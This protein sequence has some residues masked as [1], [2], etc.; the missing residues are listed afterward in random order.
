MNQKEKKQ[1]LHDLLK[2]KV[3]ESI[4]SVHISFYENGHISTHIQQ[5][6]QLKQLTLQY[7]Q[8]E[9]LQGLEPLHLEY[10]NVSNNSLTNISMIEHM[11]SLTYLDVQNNQLRKIPKMTELKHLNIS[12]NLLI[13]DKQNFIAL[14]QLTNL[15]SLVINPSIN[16]LML[17]RDEIE[18]MKDQLDDSIQVEKEV[19]KY[20]IKEKG[21]T[22]ELR[23]LQYQRKYFKTICEYSEPE[24]FYCDVYLQF[25]LLFLR[26]LKEFNY[27]PIE[28]QKKT[29]VSETKLSLFDEINSNLK[30]E[31]TFQKETPL[32]NQLHQREIGMYSINGNHSITMNKTSHFSSSHFEQLFSKE[33]RNPRQIDFSRITPG[34]F[35]VSSKHG[36]L[37]VGNIQDNSLKQL[38]SYYDGM[39]CGLQLGNTEKTKSILL[40]GSLSGMLAIYDLEKHDHPLNTFNYLER[41]SSVSLNSIGTKFSV[42]GNNQNVFIYDLEKQ[43]LSRVVGSYHTDT[44]NVVKFSNSNP[45]LYTACCY[46]KEMTL[47][48]IR[49]PC[50]YP[51]SFYVAQTPLTSTMFSYDDQSV[52]IGGEDGYVCNVDI[53]NMKPKLMK[54]ERSWN[55]KNATRA[56]YS[57]KN[58][59]IVSIDN[60]NTIHLN[61]RYDGK[62]II[63]LSYDCPDNS[64]NSGFL[65]VKSNPFDF[66]EFYVIRINRDDKVNPYSLLRTNL[67]Y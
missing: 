13:G 55:T 50:H 45:F 4:T 8:L 54:I 27:V 18:Q 26:N 47:W 15:T 3:V 16:K 29:K 7:L 34:N 10:L 57:Y 25:S 24:I 53:K 66:D 23:S 17:N 31:F 48:D 43:Q 56:I 12:D 49:E 51:S 14:K 42:S 65:S 32:L 2:K 52:V 58:D 21:Y 33:I 36:E 40:T 19:N 11:T 30:E 41:I 67:T 44:I 22:P 28:R 46:D 61:D 63:D 20:I 62:R 38:E 64:G 39:V 35:V 37:F 5:F 6:T 1:T 60:S 59:S 9:T